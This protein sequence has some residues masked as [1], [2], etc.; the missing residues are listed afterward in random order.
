M[1]TYTS[2]TVVIP[3]KLFEI[4]TYSSDITLVAAISSLF[5]LLTV[6]F[7]VGLRLTGI[8]FYELGQH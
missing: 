6:L 7:L 4:Y 2:Q 3:V 5:I 1:M 8:T